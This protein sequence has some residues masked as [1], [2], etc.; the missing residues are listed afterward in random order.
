MTDRTGEIE[1]IEKKFWQCMADKDAD[2]AGDM[3]AREALLAGPSGTMD[4][5]PD[6]YRKMTREGDWTLE[7]FE[8]DDVSVVFPSDDTAI[9]AY[10]VHQKGALKGQPMDL[11]CADSTTW[12]KQDGAWKCAL[13]TETILEGA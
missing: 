8:M 13:H 9:I 4:M 10:K 7:S 6:I 3:I 2:T 11:K 12:V 5:N 1:S